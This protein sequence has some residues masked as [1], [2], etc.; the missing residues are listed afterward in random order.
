MYPS[1]LTT[2]TNFLVVGRLCSSEPHLGG[3]RGPQPP[4]GSPGATEKEGKRWPSLRQDGHTAGGIGGG[5]AMAT[6]LRSGLL[7]E[8]S[9]TQGLASAVEWARKQRVPGQGQCDTPSTF[10]HQNI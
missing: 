1:F 2:L 6:V 8:P 4:T 9:L 3:A 7:Q 10:R 5:E